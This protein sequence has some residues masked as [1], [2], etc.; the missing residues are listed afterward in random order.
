MFDKAKY[1]YETIKREIIKYI[2]NRRH[3]ELIK[4]VNIK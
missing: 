2:Y 3:K 1:F 4:W